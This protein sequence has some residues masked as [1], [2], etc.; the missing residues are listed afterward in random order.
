VFLGLRRKVIQLIGHLFAEQTV[1]RAA[2]AYETAT[3]WRKRGPEMA[4]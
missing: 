1:F 4:S 3:E 2:Y